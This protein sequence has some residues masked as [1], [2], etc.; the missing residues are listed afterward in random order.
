MNV[1]FFSVILVLFSSNYCIHRDNGSL[2]LDITTGLKGVCAVLIL[3]YHCAV[4]L[5]EDIRFSFLSVGFYGVAL[6][7]FFSGYGLN[8]KK[9]ICGW[10]KRI[11][12]LFVPVISAT[13]LYFII[14]SL[15]KFRFS[16]SDIL[17]S[18]LGQGT[19]VNNLWY[20][21]ALVLMYAIFY[22]IGKSKHRIG[23]IS[24]ALILLTIV[25]SVAFSS[26]PQWYISNLAFLVGIF[27]SE[28]DI[29]LKKRNFWLI[30]SLIAILFSFIITRYFPSANN[31]P[32]FW[33]VSNIK[34]SGV[35]LFVVSICSFFSNSNPI[36]RFL[37]NNSFEIYLLHGLVIFVYTAIFNSINLIT[38]IILTLLTTIAMA[39]ILHIANQ[40]IIKKTCALLKIY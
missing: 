2:S 34:S 15:M 39:F 6:F 8:K 32:T 35:V 20:P 21:Y 3:L 25:E 1:L 5:R 24:L 16:I 18:F 13:I 17:L 31:S 22:F 9:D 38:L 7:F 37:G 40:I 26:Q 33:L 11:I 28:Y 30:G 19:I 14:K 10:K 23:Y 29:E 4:A 27:L 36:S 12:K